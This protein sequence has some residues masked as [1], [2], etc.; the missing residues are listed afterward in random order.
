MWTERIRKVKKDE[1]GYKTS[2][3]SKIGVSGIVG[4]Y[5]QRIRILYGQFSLH[6]FG[7]T[8]FKLGASPYLTYLFSLI[9]K[10]S[11]NFNKKGKR[12]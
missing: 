11:I 12:V 8:H 9:Y 6:P 7:R 1:K 4:V 5:M 2:Y 3:R 10:Y